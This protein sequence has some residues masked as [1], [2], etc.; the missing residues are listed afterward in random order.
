M[1][2]TN[3]FPIMLWA[4]PVVAVA[5][6]TAL[7]IRPGTWIHTNE[8]DFEPGTFENTVVTNL[9]D[10]RLAAG[11]TTVGDLPEGARIVYD[12][13]RDA[14]GV[15]YI[16]A[17]PEAKLMK[18][19]DGGIEQ[20]LALEGAQ[21]FDPCQAFKGLVDRAQLSVGAGPLHQSETLQACPAV[22]LRGGHELVAPAL[23]AG[24]IDL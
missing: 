8:A 7:A 1:S 24:P 13:A 17:G 18:R 23:D 11:T 21:V 2:I 12:L 19:T 22:A 20:V 3:R 16:A 5:V 9:G 15:L 14:G 6:S 4:I 10:V